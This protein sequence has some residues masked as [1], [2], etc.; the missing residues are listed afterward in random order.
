MGISSVRS[1]GVDVAKAVAAGRPYAS[2]EEVVRAAGLNEA[3]VEALATAGAFGSLGVARREALWA[4]GAVAQS[5][6]GRLPGV[7]VGASAPALPGMEPMEETIAD[8][9]STSVSTT[10]YPTEFVRERLD[11]LGAVAAA[12]LRGIA[13]GERVLVGG[14]VTHRQRPAT[15]QGTLFLNLED[16]TG[17]V[18]VVC[19]KGAWAHYRR[20]AR[21]APALLVRRRHEKVDGVINVIADKI[22]ELSL[23]Q[24]ALP[25][26]RDFR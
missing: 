25:K 8:L 20:A 3:Q 7:V 23:T 10:T 19:S 17:L 18:N 21:S 14:V 6:E 9:W 22:T 5:R 1:I 16:E 2:M 15:A 4:A 12:G 26:S 11:E 13:H 24:Q